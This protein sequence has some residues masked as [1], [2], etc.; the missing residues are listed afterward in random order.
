MNTEHLVFS[1]EAETC[2]AEV[3]SCAN[4]MWKY[5]VWLRI[6]FCSSDVGFACRSIQ[7]FGRFYSLNLKHFSFISST[8]ATFLLLLNVQS[9]E[10]GREEEKRSTL[11]SYNAFVEYLKLCS[12]SAIINDT[13]T[14]GNKKVKKGVIRRCT[15]NRVGER[16]M[17]VAWI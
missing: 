1:T 6:W 12:L 16:P 5:T 2:Y 15:A 13:I 17:C 8:R 7:H 9:L 10:S 11:E 14:I 4:Q 3:T